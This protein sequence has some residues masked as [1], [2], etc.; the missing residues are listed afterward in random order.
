MTPAL[1]NAENAAIEALLWYAED[2]PAGEMRMHPEPQLDDADVV[3]LLIAHEHGIDPGRISAYK[4]LAKSRNLTLEQ[5]LRAAF[6]GEL[7]QVI[8]LP[9]ARRT[10]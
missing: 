9:T 6:R 1:S 2:H 5:C 10:P 8:D 4:S 7:R 3:G